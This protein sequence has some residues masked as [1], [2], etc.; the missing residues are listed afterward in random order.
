VLDPTDALSASVERGTGVSPVLARTTMDSPAR[1]R[2]Q[3][4][5]THMTGLLVSVRNA[6]EARIAC[7]AGAAVVDVKEPARGGLGAADRG[8]WQRVVDAVGACTAV[9]VAAGEL[10]EPAAVEQLAGTRG[11]RFAK[12]GL[13]GCAAR[14][15]WP[16]SW[17]QRLDRFPSGVRR[18]AVVYADWPRCGAPPPGEVVRQAARLQCSAVLFD[19]Y[20]KD[21]S[22]LVDHLTLGELRRLAGDIRA[23]GM[24]LAL[25]G[26]LTAS[27]IPPLLRLAPDLIAVRGAACR[28][29]RIGRIDS[30]RVRRLVAIVQTG[31]SFSDPL[32][33]L[34]AT[35]GFGPPREASP[36]TRP[37]R[38]TASE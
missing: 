38:L 17:A 13:A 18:V 29:G 12:L 15:D 21:G 22:T 11:I 37:F 20:D 7:R 36:A 28:G 27:H 1:A 33:W 24:R 8:V 6:E 32:H 19:T 35:S 4:H 34:A 30:V 10:I 3:R 16:R 14:S 26:S 5:P 23:A 2:R 31:A 25:A 9:S